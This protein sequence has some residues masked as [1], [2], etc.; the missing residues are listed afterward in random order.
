MRVG[1]IPASDRRSSKIHF[2]DDVYQVPLTD[3]GKS[4]SEEFPLAQRS[5]VRK[6]YDKA[7]MD[8]FPSVERSEIC[9]VAGNKRVILSAD[10]SHQLPI[11]VPAKPDEVHVF[12]HMSGIV[13]H[14]NE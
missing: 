9:T 12:T 3:V 6:D 2:D 5:D 14:R 10:P 13:C 7:G 8:F 11:L 1:V 4:S